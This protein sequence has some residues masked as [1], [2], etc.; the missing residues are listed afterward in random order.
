MF[1]TWCWGV[2]CFLEFSWKVNGSLKS[3]E[4]YS[5]MLLDSQATDFLCFVTS[6]KRGKYGFYTPKAPVM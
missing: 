4:G 3:K 5:Q 6:W 2:V 1:V